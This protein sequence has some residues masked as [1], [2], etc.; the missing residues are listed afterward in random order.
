MTSENN[1]LAQGNSVLVLREGDVWIVLV[2]EDGKQH[3]QTF[4][5]QEHAQSYASGQR[6]RLQLPVEDGDG[7]E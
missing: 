1:E 4:V 2:S 6:I 3:S 7:F 5:R